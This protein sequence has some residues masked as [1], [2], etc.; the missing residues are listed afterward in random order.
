G[1]TT[2]TWNT[3][4]NANPLSVTPGATSYTVTG[5]TA[6]CTAKAVST[7]T[8]VANPTVTVNSPTVCT[9]SSVN[10]TGAGASTYT[11]NTGSSANPL[12]VTP[13]ATSYTVTGTSAVGCTNTAVSTVTP[14]A[15]PTYSLTS[16]SYTICNGGSQ[17]L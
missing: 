2:Y 15:L 3:G 7:V 6:G 9:G 13:G 11:W 16:N 12:S 1:A 5:T 14:V 8:I 10:L 4:S 17:T